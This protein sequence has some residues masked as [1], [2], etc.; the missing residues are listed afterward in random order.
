M[1]MDTC[2]SA[3]SASSAAHSSAGSMAKQGSITTL[4]AGSSSSETFSLQVMTTGLAPMAA[5]RALAWACVSVKLMEANASQVPW[6]MPHS[7]QAASSMTGGFPS[8]KDRA[9]FGQA[10]PQR[11]QSAPRVR[12]HRSR[13]TRMRCGI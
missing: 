8:G 5:R 13:S 2:T 10:S 9:S 12:M 1:S 7:E 4:L 11:V 3:P 6:Q